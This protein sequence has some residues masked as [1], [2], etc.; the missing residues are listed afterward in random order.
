M[1]TNKQSLILSSAVVIGFSVAGLL[2][3]L[4]NFVIVSILCL[5]FL[6]VVINL[7]FFKHSPDEIDDEINKDIDIENDSN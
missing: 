6:A 5:G 7:F 4:N 2:N 1:L 3:I